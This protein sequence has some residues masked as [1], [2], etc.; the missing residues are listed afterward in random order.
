MQR[1]AGKSPGPHGRSAVALNWKYIAPV[2]ALLAV[3]AF[4]LG[5]QPGSNSGATNAASPESN[6]DDA[7]FGPGTATPETEPTADASPTP[8]PDDEPGTRDAGDAGETGD[9]TGEPREDVASARSTPSDA[10][11]GEPSGPNA[12]QPGGT[13]GAETPG[14]ANNAQTGDRDG[15]GAELITE[16]AACGDMQEGSH[17]VA[18][19]QKLSDITV[20]ATN[21]AVY[22][23]DYLRCILLGTGG[24]AATALADAVQ[25][26]GRAGATH[27]V[28]I[29]L[30]L[31]NNGSGMAQVNLKDATILAGSGEQAALGVLNGRG[32]AVVSSGQ[33]RTVTLVAT[34]TSDYGSGTG[35]IT[36]A[37]DA[38]TK[39]GEVQ[40]GKYQLFLPTP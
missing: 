34:V 9:G 32:E 7:L 2:A 17:A 1:H 28:L 16:S 25:D 5:V 3:F 26:A 18:V 19:E 30:W 33:S 38:P 11:S 10:E 35:P 36:L 13:G 27:A 40:Q 23:V 15:D 8:L 14:G 39:D 21:V 4:A 37:I 22:P 6:A 24:E 29:D 31:A 12:D 20:R